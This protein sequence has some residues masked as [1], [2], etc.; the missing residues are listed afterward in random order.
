MKRIINESQLKKV[1]ENAV[2]MALNEIWEP[3]S[4]TDSADGLNLTENPPEAENGIYGP[5]YFK[6][7][8]VQ[9]CAF[10]G[11]GKAS[12]WLLTSFLGAKRVS[13]SIGAHWGTGARKEIFDWYSIKSNAALWIYRDEEGNY[14]QLQIGKKGLMMAADSNDSPVKDTSKF[15]WFVKHATFWTQR[16]PVL[17]SV[18]NMRAKEDEYFNSKNK[19]NH[20]QN[21]NGKQPMFHW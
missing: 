16:G 12:A 4:E 17:Q 2:K 10:N 15:K 18:R 5:A 13:N 8:G 7:N 9:R 19:N 20:Q 3:Y 11:E 14:Y 1:V 21:P 6:K